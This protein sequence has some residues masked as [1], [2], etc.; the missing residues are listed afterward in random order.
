VVSGKETL[1]ALE[2]LGF[3]VTG[4]RGSH[5][6][7]RPADGRTVIVPIRRELARGTLA[8][9]LRPARLTVEEFRAAL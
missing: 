8:S 3:A 4:G 2:R 7:L 5:R 6:K 1:Q 9:V